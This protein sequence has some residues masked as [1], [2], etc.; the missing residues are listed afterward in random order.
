MSKHTS[1]LAGSCALLLGLSAT[2]LHAETLVE[3]YAQAL[4]SDP[5]FKEAEAAW[6]AAKE[7]IPISQ[8][9]LLPSLDLNASYNRIYSKIGAPAVWANAQQYNVVLGQPIINF[10]SWA[11]LHSTQDSVK[12]A[13]ATYAAAA[14][15]LMFRT[16]QA[17]IAVLEADDILQFTLAQKRSTLQDLQSAQQ[18]YAVGLTAITGVYQAQASYDAILAT[19]IL[20]RN[21]IA[22]ALENLRAISG[23]SYTALNGILHQVPLA[24]PQ[25]AQIDRWVEMAKEESPQIK[26]QYYTMLAAQQNIKQ[27]KA[28]FY[29]TLTANGNYGYS[30]A[31][32]L[33]GNTVS[34]SGALGLTMDLPAYS[35]G[36]T[37][38]Q[39]RQARYNY[40]NASAALEYTLRNIISQ[41]RQSYLTIVAFISQ[42]HADLEAIKSAQNAYESTQAGYGA[43][44]QTMIDVLQALS[45]L[46][47]ARQQY[48]EDQY[49]YLLG[50]ISL[51]Q[52]AGTLEFKDLVEMSAWL[53]KS[54][55]VRRDAGEQNL[56]QAPQ[57]HP[58]SEAIPLLEK[59]KSQPQKIILPATKNTR[60]SLPAPAL[61]ENHHSSVIVQS[62]PDA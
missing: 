33:Q 16:V 32:Q 19:E 61:S 17:Y 57:T 55:A 28:G 12:A 23:Y 27:M 59:T 53:K 40:V 14:Q 1:L 11:N 58:K 7:N 49:D 4:N 5:T 34:Q 43:G 52:A 42:I 56:D 41:T 60:L 39:T 6:L 37:L 29:P 25:P 24:T 31:S 44:T 48:A 9:N 46:Y 2:P 38:A 50:I 15:N 8:A 3:V 62:T 21:N 18:K 36:A 47:Q 13:A 22:T 20:N 35:G 51:K 26:A 30:S 54:I 45:N 10:A